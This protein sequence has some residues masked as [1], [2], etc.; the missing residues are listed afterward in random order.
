MKKLKKVLS[1]ALTLMMLTA[2]MALPAMGAGT[3]GSITI[4]PPS[5]FSIIGQEFTII[6]IFDA[7]V[8]PGTP[9]TAAYTLNLAFDEFDDYPDPTTQTLAEFIGGLSNDHPDLIA[10]AGKLYAYALDLID[11][12]D[13]TLGDG[14]F[15]ATATAETVTFSDLPYGYYLVYG[16]AINS[17]DE[18]E[19]VAACS[20]NTTTPNMSVT[21][22]LD[23]PEI[24]K[25]VWNHN[26]TTTDKWDEWTDVNISDKVDFRIWSEVPVM[27]GYDRYWFIVT[28]TMSKGLTLIDDF[29][30]TIGGGTPLT[31]G[32]D[33]YV[34]IVEDYSGGTNYE[35]ST[36]ITIRFDPDMFV[37]CVP[38]SS[39]EIRYSAT[40]NEDAII[41]QNGNPN[42]V[43]LQYSN[44][45]YNVGEGDFD[46]DSE[47]GPD[48]GDIGET[49]EIE[50]IVYTYK[51]DIYKFTGDDDTDIP[52]TPLPGAEFELYIGTAGT[53]KVYFIEVDAG[54][55]DD[56]AIYRVAKSTES[57]SS[58]VLTSPDSG[59]ISIIGLDAA[60]YRLVEK[61]APAGGYNLDNTARAVNIVKGTI[62][63]ATKVVSYTVN[64]VDP[65]TITE[66]PAADI[67]F[68]NGAGNLFPSTGG[69]GRTIFIAVGVALMAGAVVAMVVR[70]KVSRMVI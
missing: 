54:D 12:A 45:P 13:L 28:D 26:L 37:T 66:E 6:R 22:K 51:V 32:D 18:V 64:G 20:L 24:H 60:Y 47:E 31:R 55:D 50:V 27:Y 21:L 52:G 57:G 62:V 36:R 30:I 39:I 10:L 15:K 58:T 48:V 46:D 53:D 29:T 25:E 33:Y 23:A 2:L 14:Y 38:E 8:T 34:V 44:N 69:I 3:D 5:G 65:I 59:L 4:T 41:A 70:R 17:S 35:D 68:Y 42:K 49:P 11:S 16:S 63:P 9:P 43:F 1:I 19:V 61:T 40:L 67:Y 7:D 56:P